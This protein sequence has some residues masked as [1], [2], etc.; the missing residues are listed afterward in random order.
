MHNNNNNKIYLPVTSEVTQLFGGR[1]T[2]CRTDVAEASQ[3]QP[4]ARDS[5]SLV[6]GAIE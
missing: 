1:D 4:A 6:N 5:R 2:T 3:Y